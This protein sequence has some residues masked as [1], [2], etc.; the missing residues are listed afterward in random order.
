VYSG[1]QLHMIDGQVNPIFAIEEMSFYEVTEWLVFPNAAPFVTTVAGSP[2]F[3]AGLSPERRRLVSG[4]IDELHEAIDGIQQRYNS[5][6]LQ[7]M[8]QRK[9]ALQ[10]LTLDAAQRQSF[11]TAAAPVAETFKALA[12]MRGERLLGTLTA[13]VE[14]AETR[15]R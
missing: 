7:R 6:R 15:C 10:S 12:G 9:P 4:V 11:R 13:A 2:E 1:L 5:Q 8:R 3:F 14:R